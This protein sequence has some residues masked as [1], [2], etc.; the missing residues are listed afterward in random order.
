MVVFSK[1]GCCMCHVVKHLF[2]SL[3]LSVS[4]TVYELDDLEQQSDATDATTGGPATTAEDVEKT[5][6]MRL[7]QQ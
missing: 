5:L 3:S 7:V 1:S 4:P 6:L 2:S